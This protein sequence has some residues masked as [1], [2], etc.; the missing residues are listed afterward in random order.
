M[1][2]S[3]DGTLLSAASTVQGD[4]TFSLSFTV[5]PNIGSGTHRVTVSDGTNQTE[6]A[7]RTAALITLDQNLAAIGDRVQVD[8]VGFLAN[9]PVTLTL[10]GVQV[11]SAIAD[12]SG[13]FQIEVTVL[14]LP[15]GNYVV[16]ARDSTN[17]AS[18]DI[19]ITA[20][21]SVEPTTGAVGT[22]VSVNGQGFGGNVQIAYD[23]V[24]VATALAT[25]GAFSASFEVP[26][27]TAGDHQVV[28]SDGTTTMDAVF[29][30]ES[31][32][33]PVPATVSPAADDKAKKAAV[34]EWAEVTDESGVVYHL[35]VAADAELSTV[36][37]EKRDLEQSQ[38]QL[39]DEEELPVPER[40][41]SY[42]WR[43]RAQDAAGN[44]SEW[45]APTAFTV[46]GLQVGPIGTWVGVG[47]GLVLM[48]VLGFW[49]GR[50][51]AYY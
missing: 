50:R 4:G 2:V 37:L 17:V 7:F 10:N 27:S 36:I 22:A 13:V 30:V 29:T 38:Y 42:Y 46:G 19:T 33:P 41:T 3:F 44:A 35:Q 5:P 34:F 8:G 43:V 47:I 6:L 21:L 12:G 31:E 16:E 40:G 49:F 32:P 25:G 15:I 39:T 11:G 45:S 48:L 24:E 9:Q 20:T 28:V 18:A 14:S 51:T 1:S 26:V 23:R